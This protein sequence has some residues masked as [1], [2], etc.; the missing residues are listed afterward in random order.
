MSRPFVETQTTLGSVGAEANILGNNL[1]GT[2]EITFNG[3]A[4]T[5]EVV[6]ETEITATSGVVVVTTP[7]GV[8]KTHTV[9]TVQ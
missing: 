4:A 6:S 5:F 1:T 3:T 9:Y 2:A 8:L 7:K